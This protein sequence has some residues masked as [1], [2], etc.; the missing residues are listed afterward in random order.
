[1]CINAHKSQG[2]GQKW[3]YIGLY[4]NHRDKRDGN[5]NH[6]GFWN[7]SRALECHTPTYHQQ[8]AT[9]SALAS[10]TCRCCNHLAPPW[11]DPHL[12]N[13]LLV[14]DALFVPVF[15]SPTKLKHISMKYSRNQNRRSE[16]I[17]RINPITNLSKL[18]FQVI[19]QFL[20]SFGFPHYRWHLLLQMADDV[21]MYLC[22]SCPFHKL[23][24][25]LDRK[26]MV[27]SNQRGGNERRK[28]HTHSAIT[29]FLWNV[30]QISKKVILL[31]FKQLSP[32]WTSCSFVYGFITKRTVQSK[33]QGH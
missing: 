7:F 18:V 13:L 27:K 4:S 25:L 17:R 9:F 22:C 11:N 15:M 16:M 31:L 8:S 29:S 26:N 33:K 24:Y 30:F 5:I 21:R 28:V 1:M 20:L 6:K 10:Q 2:L 12:G 23:I 14:S 32:N 3:V 19:Y